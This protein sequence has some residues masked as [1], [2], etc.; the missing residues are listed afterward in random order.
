MPQRIEMKSSTV[1]LSNKFVNEEVDNEKDE[2]AVQNQQSPQIRRSLDAKTLRSAGNQ[3][4]FLDTLLN[5]GGRAVGFG[6]DDPGKLEN[7]RLVAE[8]KGHN[9]LYPYFKLDNPIMYHSTNFNLSR[10]QTS[11]ALQD[12]QGIMTGGGEIDPN[13]EVFSYTTSKKSLKSSTMRLSA[14]GGRSI[15]SRR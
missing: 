10:P 13:D 12:S 1:S 2:M 7:N 14:T 3:G 15:K 8:R 11:G 9:R 4:S 5:Y 6:E